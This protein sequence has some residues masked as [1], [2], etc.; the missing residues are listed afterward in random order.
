MSER[1]FRVILGLMLFTALTASALLESQLPVY[2]V[3]AILAFE[4]I[5]NWRIPTVITHLRHGKNHNSDVNKA[6]HNRVMGHFEAERILR[7]MV[8][9]LVSIPYFTNIQ[10]INILPWFVA[11]AL[12]LAGVTNICPMVM[13][14]RYIGMR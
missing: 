4:A 6:V 3:L 8:M 12:V 9:M 11:T 14:L 2:I 7:V 5:T 1:V 10:Y 13:S